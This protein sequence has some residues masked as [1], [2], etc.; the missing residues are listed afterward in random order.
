M[1]L[2]RQTPIK[3]CA[4]GSRYRYRLIPFVPFLGPGLHP[5]VKNLVT[6]SSVQK[7]FGS[8]EFMRS[9]FFGLLATALIMSC[10][11]L[12]QADQSTLG[13]NG[14]NSYNGTWLRPCSTTAGVGS[15][16][17][18]ILVDADNSNFVH[19]EY[20]YLESDTTCV[21]TR[22]MTAQY[23]GNFNARSASPGYEI[24]V[25]NFSITF[26]VEEQNTLD[27]FN[28]ASYCGFNNWVINVAKPVTGLSCGGALMP[29]QF[30]SIFKVDN[31]NRLYMGALDA[32]HDGTTPA[33]RPTTYESSYYTH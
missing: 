16:K 27:S 3:Y 30:Y 18:A 7:L 11:Q 12:K 6:I 14:A 28:T 10:S 9:I 22:I 23:V 15:A 31:N 1:V 32:S 5:W 29:A 26:T 13:S 20:V 19:T 8:G 21:G 17:H 25:P 4:V 2:G 33:K 24:D